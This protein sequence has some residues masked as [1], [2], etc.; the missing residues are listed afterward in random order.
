MKKFALMATVAATVWVIAVTVI[1]LSVDG[2]YGGEKDLFAID[3]VFVES[4]TFMMGCT[5]EQGD[6][7]EDIVK[8]VRSVTVG[9]FY[10][11]KYE[12]TQG[13][14]KSVMGKN[15]SYFKG[16]DSLPVEHVSY[17]DAMAFIQ[18]LNEKTGRKY[19]LPTESEWEFAARGGNS[20]KGYRYSGS[21][22]IDDVAWYDKNSGEKTHPVGT[23]QPNELG[24]YDMSGNVWEWTSDTNNGASSLTLRGGTYERDTGFCRVSR[25]V[26]A[27]PYYN[28]SV[29]GFRLVRD[30]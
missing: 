5:A 18:K 12:V 17:S 30:P 23:K 21:N 29:L 19:R 26:V 27:G 1:M 9:D 20:G 2:D 7:G 10:L 15:P 25:R 14:W 6:D 24:I 13:L 22:N 4:G 16:G 28:A 3:M 11:G 8:K